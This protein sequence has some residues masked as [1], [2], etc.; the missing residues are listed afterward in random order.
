MTNLLDAC[1]GE[2]MEADVGAEVLVAAFAKI[3]T[4]VAIKY[5]HV[6]TGAATK[7]AHVSTGAARKYRKGALRSLGN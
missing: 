3:S 2:G 4:G 1:D 6:S 5:A 7:H